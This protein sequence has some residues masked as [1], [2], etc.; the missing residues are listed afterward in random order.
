MN[1][2]F[3]CYDRAM[4]QFSRRELLNLAWKLGTAALVTPLVPR[5]LRTSSSAMW[6]VRVRL[7]RQRADVRD[8]EI[9]VQQRRRVFS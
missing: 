4:R 2:A 1:D 7:F 3:R 8:Q 5:S 6:G 9:Q